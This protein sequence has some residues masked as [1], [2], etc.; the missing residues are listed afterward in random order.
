MSKQESAQVSRTL[1]LFLLLFTAV[2]LLAASPPLCRDS[3]IAQSAPCLECHQEAAD[4]LK[5][6]VHQ[7]TFVSDKMTRL[8]VGCVGC[9]TGWQ[10]HLNDPSKDNIDSPAELTFTK[11]AET[12]RGC[13]QNGHQ[14]AMITTDPHGR[15]QL[16][17]TTCHTVHGN[18]AKGLVKDD[19]NNFCG[20]CHT[21]VMAQFKSRSA[22][23]L[24]TENIRCASCHFPDNINDA[25]LARGMDW[26]CQNC[27]SE[28][29]GP[30]A[31]EH[32]VT[33]S[34]LFNGG[35]C[36]ECH[37]PHGSPNDRLLAQPG[38][39]VCLQCHAVPPK[40]RTAHSGM[41]VKVSCVNCHSDFHG[42]D[43]N[44]LFLD[45]QLNTKFFADCFHSGC[46]DGVR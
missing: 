18:H 41:G 42:S 2:P 26:T 11:Q 37:N 29:S 19:K 31:F 14:A 4:N 40:H 1:L 3:L 33:Q 20:T 25:M 43:D 35:G 8:A 28:Y 6:S 16:G 32:P 34:H 15:A 27:H 13:H 17:C 39:G 12:C 45:P 9:H 36:T 38:N 22:H 24:V 23:P 7:L 44:C 30:H 10:N 46:H 5:G 21:G